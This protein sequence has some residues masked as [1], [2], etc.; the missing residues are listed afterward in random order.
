MKIAG[1]VVVAGTATLTGLPGTV[2][3]ATPGRLDR[4]AIT[5]GRE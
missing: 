2:N 4:L 3:V 1:K 5:P